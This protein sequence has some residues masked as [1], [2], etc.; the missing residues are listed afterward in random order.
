MFACASKTPEPLLCRLP[1]GSQLLLWLPPHL[2]LEGLKLPRPLD[3]ETG[4]ACPEEPWKWP[5]D[6]AVGLLGWALGPPLVL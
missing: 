1:L 6:G 3:S 4:Q 5:L 2:Y